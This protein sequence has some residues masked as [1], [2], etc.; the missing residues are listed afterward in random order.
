MLQIACVFAGYHAIRRHFKQKG[1]VFMHDQDILDGPQIRAAWTVFAEAFCVD[2]REYSVNFRKFSV[3]SFLDYL[4]GNPPSCL[5][6]SS[7]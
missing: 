4:S 1:E 6:D 7:H 5:M 3:P 2:A